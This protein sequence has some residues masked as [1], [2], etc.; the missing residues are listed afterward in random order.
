MSTPSSG[1]PSLSR[2]GL[3][4]AAGIVVAGAGFSS[5]GVLSA[6]S[7]HA[8]TAFH[9]IN[10]YSGKVLEVRGSST[11]NDG[12]VVTWANNGTFTQQWALVA[13]SG[14]VTLTNRNSGK[15]LE[16]PRSSTAEG[17]QLVQYDANGTATQQWQLKPTGDGYYQWLVNRNSGKVAGVRAAGDG[18]AVTQQTLDSGYGQHWQFVPA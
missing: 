2:R 11:V 14:F 9:L 1:L 5:A 4:R 12:P 10:R 18:S 16:V 6:T 8:V 7:A 17:T 13:D 3:F 15:V